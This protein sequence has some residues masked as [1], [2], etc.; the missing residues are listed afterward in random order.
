MEDIVNNTNIKVFDNFI[1]PEDFSKLE[2]IFLA[3]NFP[4][5]YNEYVNYADNEEQ[6]FQFTHIFYKDNEPKSKLIQNIS[7]ILEKI[8]IFSLYRIK[9]NLTTKTNVIEEHGYHRDVKLSNN[10]KITTAIFYINSNDGYTLFEDGSKIHSVANR[11]VSFP[12]YLEH[13][14]TSCTDE[15][16]R[17]VLN[18][19]Y[20]GF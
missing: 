4:W 1:H 9:A 16:V 8:D 15:K 14:G 13:S 18:F 3:N 5:Y 12:S 19:N 11:F 2:Q 17:L 7:P 10:C 20:I 6:S